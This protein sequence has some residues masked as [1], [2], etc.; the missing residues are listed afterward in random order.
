MR[1]QLRGCIKINACGKNLYRFINDIHVSRISCFSQYVR[2]GTLSAEI[3]RSDLGRVGELAEKHGVELKSFEFD[4]LSSEVIRRR[5]RFGIIIGLVLVIAAS[6]YFSGVVVT[7]DVQGNERVSDTA[8]LSALDE[9]DIHSGTPFGQ[10]DYINCENKLRV[11]VDGIS[12]AG[13]HRTGNRL[14]VEVTEVVE[15][16][17][18]VRNRIPCNLVAA[19]EAEITYTS[20][21]D[22][23]LMHIVGDYVRPGDMIV[24]GVTTDDTGHTTL[25]H[26]MGTI[27]GIYRDEAIFTGE[28][29]R[30][31]LVPTGESDTRRELRLF[32]LDVPLCFGKNSYEYR[33]GEHFSKPLSAF[34]CTLP[35]SIETDRYAELSRTE[36][37]LTAEELSA[38]LMEK[39]Y[40]YEKNFLTN[41]DIIERDIRT[42]EK[43]GTLT[44]TVSYRLEGDICKNMEILMK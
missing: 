39:V 8:I 38:E 7:I 9:M 35:I 40:L 27:K 37:T 19:K 5:S 43:D 13:M 2:H 20:V 41:C 10:I 17:E 44:M 1:D 11:M 32:S 14:V 34:G 28:F 16:P 3:Y 33:S 26:A 36:T 15:K 6:L 24:S 18:M 12:W 4:T 29:S 21:L 22:G 42:E 30:E 23:R 31:R 25:H